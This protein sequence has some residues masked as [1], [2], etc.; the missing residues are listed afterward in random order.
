MKIYSY[1]HFLLSLHLWF[2]IRWK[3]ILNNRQQYLL[4]KTKIPFFFFFSALVAVNLSPHFPLGKLASQKQTGITQRKQTAINNKEPRVP[5]SFPGKMAIIILA[6]AKA[7]PGHAKT[8][9]WYRIKTEIKLDLGTQCV[10][11]SVTSLKSVFSLLVY[12]SDHWV[13]YTCCFLAF[14]SA[15]VD[16]FQ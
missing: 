3:K 2:V 9:G 7:E 12:S 11:Q 1:S 14:A 15:I 4:I 8:K 13:E 16:A 6:N 5:S 10:L